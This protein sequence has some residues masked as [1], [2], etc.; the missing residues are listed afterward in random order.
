MLGDLRT[1]IPSSSLDW[2]ILTIHPATLKRLEDKQHNL[3][4]LLIL[5][6]PPNPLSRLLELHL[7]H[8]LHHQF[9]YD[10]EQSFLLDML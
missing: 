4:E 6:C 7:H 2:V 10:T 1:I 5:P 3:L 9:A 8:I